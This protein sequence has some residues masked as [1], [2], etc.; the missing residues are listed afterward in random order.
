MI[1]QPITLSFYIVYYPFDY[2]PSRDIVAI[3]RGQLLYHCEDTTNNLF[4]FIKSRF[5]FSSS[6]IV[7]QYHLTMNGPT[8][9]NPAMSRVDES[10]ATIWHAVA[11]SDIVYFQH[12]LTD[13]SLIGSQYENAGSITNEKI[14][15]LDVY[16][17]T[18]FIMFQ[19]NTDYMFMRVNATT[20]NVIQLY[21]FQTTTIQ[22]GVF[23]YR[24]YV[25]IIV[26]KVSS[27]TRSEHIQ[28]VSSFN[29]T[30]L[31][32]I[33]ISNLLTFNPTTSS[34]QALTTQ[35][36]TNHTALSVSSTIFSSLSFAAGSFE[37]LQNESYI[38]SMRHSLQY[39]INVS[40]NQNVTQSIDLP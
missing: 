34:Q 1:F 27:T 15:G 12:N 16:D 40:E 35:S 7:E 9:V 21:A 28:I 20:Q 8:G 38:I 17:N 30:D 39:N 29:Q 2:T 37:L 6:K 26:A 14:N 4:H 19:A 36:N 23:G 11:N 18:V 25:N 13:F 32:S 22:F 10:N 24:G 33:N 31:P 5:S 3:T